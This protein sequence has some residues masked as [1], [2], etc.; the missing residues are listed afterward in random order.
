MPYIHFND[1][2]D[3]GVSLYLSGFLLCTVFAI[4]TIANIIAHSLLMGALFYVFGDRT[5]YVLL[6]GLGELAFKSAIVI[7]IAWPL[8]FLIVIT[9]TRSTDPKLFAEKILNH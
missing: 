8:V 9:K 3:F 2:K 6:F 4:R 7:S 1:L 5:K